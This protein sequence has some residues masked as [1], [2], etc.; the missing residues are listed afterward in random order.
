MVEKYN[1]C[2]LYLIA[3]LSF[4]IGWSII[5]SDKLV[6]RGVTLDISEFWKY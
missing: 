3:F 2:F 1:K 6:F 5:N 4:Y